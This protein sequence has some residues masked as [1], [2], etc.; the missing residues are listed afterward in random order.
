MS[1]SMDHGTARMVGKLP[2]P[3]RSSNPAELQM[4]AFHRCVAS[5][6]SEFSLAPTSQPCLPQRPPK[7][8]TRQAKYHFQHQPKRLMLKLSQELKQKFKQ[9]NHQYKQKVTLPLTTAILPTVMICKSTHRTRSHGISAAQAYPVPPTP[10][11]SLQV[12]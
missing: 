7:N 1:R 12:C 9:Y 5:E 4:S 8:K 3:A 6:T 2:P 11:L 10:H